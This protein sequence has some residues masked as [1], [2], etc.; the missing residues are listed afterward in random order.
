MQS[1]CRKK[2][3]SYPE[4]LTFRLLFTRW[5]N[6]FRFPTVAW[7][8]FRRHIQTRYGAQP[9]SDV[10]FQVFTVE[11]VEIMVFWV[12]TLVRSLRRFRGKCYLN[13][14]KDSPEPI[15]TL[16]MKSLCSPKRRKRLVILCDIRNQMVVYE[17]LLTRR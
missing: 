1:N 17:E 2:R 12:L 9:V 4:P 16:K 3:Y 10:S 7:V 5:T 6:D 14:V 11:T 15:V 8:F 13:L